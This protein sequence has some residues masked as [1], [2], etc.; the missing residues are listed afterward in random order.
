MCG[1]GGETGQESSTKEDGGTIT[2]EEDLTQS[3]YTGS[4]LSAPNM[5]ILPSQ[6]KIWP[7]NNLAIVRVS[8]NIDFI[9]DRLCKKGERTKISYKRWANCCCLSFST[10]FQLCRLNLGKVGNISQVLPPFCAA[11]SA[12]FKMATAAITGSTT[13][14]HGV[15]PYKAIVSNVTLISSYQIVSKSKYCICLIL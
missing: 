3:V 5:K 9:L 12:D 13:N 1:A 10:L 4:V 11:W 8:N 2:S 15:S 7:L 14:G 6:L